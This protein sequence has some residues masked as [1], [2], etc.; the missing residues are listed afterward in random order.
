MVMCPR[1]GER[2]KHP[3]VSHNLFSDTYRCVACD[4]LFPV[5]PDGE[6]MD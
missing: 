3:F 1:C 5:C 6:L 2:G 4:Q